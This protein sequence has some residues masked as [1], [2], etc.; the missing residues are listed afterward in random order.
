VVKVQ[1]TDLIGL[2]LFWNQGGAVR[3]EAGPSGKK[4]NSK[5][6]VQKHVLHSA[7]RG[8]GWLQAVGPQ[9]RV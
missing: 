8:L 9:G 7:L 2:R 5:L 4:L 3:K 1:S 6:P